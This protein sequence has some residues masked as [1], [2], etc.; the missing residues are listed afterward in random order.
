MKQLSK[1]VLVIALVL[2]AGFAGAQNNVKLGHIDSNK[3]L[4]SM[5]GKDVLEKKLMDYRTSLESQ[6]Q[7]MYVEYQSKVEGYKENSASMSD[8]IRQSK[9]T[10]IR[11][12]EQRI[13]A[14]Q[15]T[16]EQDFQNKRSELFNPLLEKA[17]AAITKV[18]K[19]NGFTYVFDISMG[20][21]L[22]YENGE[23]MMPLV[24]KELG[25]TEE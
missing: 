3:L 20:G 8:L 12:M 15:K 22:F 11:E 5:P 13:Q 10:E 9:E 1:L 7:S 24:K 21:I 16:I 2:S 6:M 18:S 17:Q 14:F 19:D 25:I 4:S 23:D